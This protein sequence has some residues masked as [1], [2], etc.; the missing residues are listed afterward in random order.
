M[1]SLPD[2]KPWRDTVTYGLRNLLRGLCAVRGG[3]TEGLRLGGRILFKGEVLE[4]QPKSSVCASTG[5]RSGLSYTPTSAS[6][7]SFN[8]QLGAAGSDG[9]GPWLHGPSLPSPGGDWWPM[10]IVCM[11]ARLCTRI[12]THAK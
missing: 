1:E 12:C 10:T 3:R 6:S 9:P 2:E 5:K 4:L 8:T 7:G 11:R